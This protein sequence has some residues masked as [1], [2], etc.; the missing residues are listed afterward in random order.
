MIKCN[1]NSSH[2]SAGVD[3]DDC[4]DESRIL[5]LFLHRCEV[6]KKK[7]NRSSASNEQLR[8]DLVKMYLED[9]DAK[10]TDFSR[11]RSASVD[12]PDTS[13]ASTATSFRSDTTHDEPIVTVNAGKDSIHSST[14]KCTESAEWKLVDD[15]KYKQGIVH[16][17][18]RE[19]YINEPDGTVD[20]NKKLVRHVEGQDRTYE[21]SAIARECMSSVAECDRAPQKSRAQEARGQDSNPELYR[22]NSSK[23]CRPHEGETFEQSRNGNPTQRSTQG[24]DIVSI[25]QQGPRDEGLDDIN[26]VTTAAPSPYQVHQAQPEEELKRQSLCLPPI[27]SQPQTKHV[28]VHT[29]TIAKLQTIVVDVESA[30]GRIHHSDMPQ[31]PESTSIGDWEHRVPVKDRS[32]SVAS[33]IPHLFKSL[34]AERINNHGSREKMPVS[35]SHSHTPTVSRAPHF[36]VIKPQLSHCEDTR[37]PSLIIPGPNFSV[38]ISTPGMICGGIGVGGYQ[39]HYNTLNDN[40]VSRSANPFVRGTGERVMSDVCVPTS[41]ASEN[42][43]SEDRPL[44]ISMV[45]GINRNN[46]LSNPLPPNVGENGKRK[47]RKVEDLEK[48]YPCTQPDCDRRYASVQARYLHI[49]LK[50]RWGETV[51]E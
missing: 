46:F 39:A 6:D 49:R 48:R 51:D 4:D 25:S 17:H 18:T 36:V 7:S 30:V 3:V 47:R 22:D 16:T 13:R 14:A 20:E 8:S 37:A 26:N 42:G 28:N 2:G 45:M 35:H 10:T 43:A 29:S 40:H 9:G 21:E 5:S 34:S 23:I 38:R 44:D 32:T 33:E 31:M 27:Y 19:D 41:D 15:E 50:H 24:D 1:A 12:E 11:A